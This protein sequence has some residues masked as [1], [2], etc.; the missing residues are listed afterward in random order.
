MKFVQLYIRINLPTNIGKNANESC[1][2]SMK[3]RVTSLRGINSRADNR[4]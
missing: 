2:S 4:T 3:C 1:D